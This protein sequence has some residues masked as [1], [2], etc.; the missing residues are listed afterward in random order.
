[1]PETKAS[2]EEVKAL[3]NEKRPIPVKTKTIKE[4][5]KEDDT[6]DAGLKMLGDWIVD[7]YITFN[8]PVDLA[9]Q[10]AA[11]MIRGIKATYEEGR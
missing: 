9:Y 5:I 10:V 3:F 11:T 2:M 4:L 6:R 1:M 7:T 8:A